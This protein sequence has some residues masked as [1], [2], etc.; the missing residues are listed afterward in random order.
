MPLSEEE[1]RALEQMERALS[2]EDPKFASALQGTSLHR[3]QRR[4]ALISGVAFVGGVGLLMAGVI[5]GLWLVGI[6]GF[7]V[8]LASSTVGLTALRGEALTL[9]RL[10]SG[11][12]DHSVRKR[13]GRLRRRRP[14]W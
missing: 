13:V 5:T 2:A 10:R 11:D 8:M 3:S 7:L 1:L 9:P 4:R 6:L 12:P 14:G